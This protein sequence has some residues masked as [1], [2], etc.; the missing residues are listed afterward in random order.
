VARYIGKETYHMYTEKSVTEAEQAS[1]IN[2]TIGNQ[3]L[4]RA[5]GREENAV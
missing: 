4:L 2:E 5:F 1:F 3:K